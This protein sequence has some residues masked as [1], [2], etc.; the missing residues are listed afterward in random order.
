MGIKT[1]TGTESKNMCFQTWQLRVQFGMDA[2]KKG[3]FYSWNH[4]H[5]LNLWALVNT[6]HA[7]FH[8][9]GYTNS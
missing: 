3:T 6:N 8:W 2:V 5:T 4:G 9:E 7:Q 1:K